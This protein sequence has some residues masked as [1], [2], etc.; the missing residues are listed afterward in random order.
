[1][2]FFSR[3]KNLPIFGFLAFSSQYFFANKEGAEKNYYPSFYGSSSVPD[4]RELVFAKIIEKLQTTIHSKTHDKDGTKIENLS[5]AD[6]KVVKALQNALESTAEHLSNMDAFSSQIRGAFVEALAGKGSNASS[7]PAAI[8]I[9]FLKPLG[10]SF[11]KVATT[12]WE[13]AWTRVGSVFRPALTALGFAPKMA[14]N[15]IKVFKKSIQSFKSALT[16]L[17]KQSDLSVNHR[18]AFNINLSKEQKLEDKN[19]PTKSLEE[20]F[21]I[22]KMFLSK[23]RIIRDAASSILEKK[24]YPKRDLAMQ[25]L[26][27]IK[28]ELDDILAIIEGCYTTA[29]F[30]K[31]VIMSQLNVLS[32]SIL[33]SCDM[34][35]MLIYNKSFDRSGYA[36]GMYGSGKDF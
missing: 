19:I 26:A 35:E 1:M 18:N 7:I 13:G 29:D 14:D 22:K 28:V 17:S 36:S 24:K 23:I 10:K 6:K 12:A 20:N 30:V 15:E 9:A 8:A 21:P 33:S 16:Y 4:P 3:A 31:D 34:L 27:S 5:D 2:K 32:D 25:L 11:D